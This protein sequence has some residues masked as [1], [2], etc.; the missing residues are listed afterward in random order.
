M[1][2]FLLAYAKLN[3][4]DDLFLEFI[5][6]RYPNV[7]FDII[8]DEKYHDIYE[9]FSN[10]NPKLGV[11]DK[12]NQTLKNINID[13]YD[14]FV[15]IGGSIFMEHC[16][17]GVVGIKEFERFVKEAKSKEKPFFYISSNFG[18]YTTQEYVEA[19]KSLFENCEDVCF[20]DTY[21]K[22]IFKD[23][24]SVRYEPDLIF[25]Y[26]HKKTEIIKNTVGISI[27]DLGIRDNLKDKENTYLEFLKTNIEKY[28][29]Q[30]KTIN[31]FSFCE[32]EGDKIAADKLI[33]KLGEDE[34]NKVKIVNYDGNIAKYLETYAQMEYMIC[35]RFH[36]MVLSSIMEQK[37]FV[38]S[39]SK[40]TNNLINDLNL[41][42]AVLNLEDLKIQTDLSEFKYEKNEENLN[43]KKAEKQ[44]EALDNFIGKV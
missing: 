15:Y 6:T 24:K 19:C 28:V 23:I 34:R 37:Y 12:K 7:E 9:K 20:R 5:S 2:I 36:A 18:P 26:P 30:G 14:A 42:K 40:K 44:F 16:D 32:Y 33:Q 8:V 29:K 27:I 21:S 38:I 3:L 4:G 39:Y 22:N 35:T 13:E 41:T 11:K 25:A 31:I 1:K 43:S 17:E 10:V